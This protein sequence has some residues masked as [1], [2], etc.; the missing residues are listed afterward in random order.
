LGHSVQVAEKHYLGLIRIAPD[1]RDL[2]TAMGVNA[3]LERVISAVAKAESV[4]LDVTR[5]AR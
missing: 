1:A 3:Q 5:K 4:T 2:E